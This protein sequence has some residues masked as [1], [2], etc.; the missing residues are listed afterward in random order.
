MLVVKPE[1]KGDT[2]KNASR[3][4]GARSINAAQTMTG[5]CE[6]IIKTKPANIGEYVPERI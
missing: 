2:H 5:R 6:V 3:S 4:L 1:L